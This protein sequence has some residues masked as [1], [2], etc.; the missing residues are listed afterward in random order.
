LDAVFTTAP[1]P[2]LLA[3]AL[4]GWLAALELVLELFELPP[5][6]ASTAAAANTG[7]RN[8][9]DVGTVCLLGREPVLALGS[10][11]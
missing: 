11:L 2:S 5:Q 8:F 1:E 10:S 4:A 9:A 3:G 6:P 7:M